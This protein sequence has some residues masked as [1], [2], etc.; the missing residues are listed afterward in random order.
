MS[1][2]SGK[3]YVL[4]LVA[5]ERQL[6]EA[7][8]MFFEQ[9]DE[10]AIH[11][12]ASAA[13]RILRDMKE[14]RGLDEAADTQFRGIFYLVRDYRRGTL[15][16]EVREDADLIKFIKN[17]A[18]QLPVI[19]ETTEFRDIQTTV[20]QAEKQTYWRE[21]NTAAN[22]LKHADC[23][24]GKSLDLDRV[25]NLDLLMRTAASYLDITENTLPE[26][27]EILLIYAVVE[28]QVIYTLEGYCQE[29][30]ELLNQMGP[31][32]RLKACLSYIDKFTKV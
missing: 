14:K 24:S 32:E 11:T 25:N 22:F 18:D 5:A 30:A 10:L 19:K 27:L 20:S 12:V 8:R 23:D 21:Y 31:R 28:N 2:M 29:I 7:I 3:V 13:Y 26:E 16:R 9:R 6:R 1:E 15:P 4:K 17:K